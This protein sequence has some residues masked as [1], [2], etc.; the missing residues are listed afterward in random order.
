MIISVILIVVSGLVLF[1]QWLANR[2]YLGSLSKLHID[3]AGADTG[4]WEI[5][6][7]GSIIIHFGLILFIVSLLFLIGFVYYKVIDSKGGFMKDDN[8]DDNMVK[9]LLKGYVIVAGIFTISAL[10]S[11]Y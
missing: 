5:S 3:L 7:L 4:A 10:L 2:G 11:L 8:T 6:N 1:Y 9:F